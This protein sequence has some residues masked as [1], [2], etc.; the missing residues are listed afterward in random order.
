M[1]W[2]ECD[3][4]SA[5]ADPAGLNALAFKSWLKSNHLEWDSQSMQL[6]TKSLGSSPMKSGRAAALQVTTDAPVDATTQQQQQQQQQEQ[7]LASFGLNQSVTSCE[8]QD[9]RYSYRYGNQVEYMGGSHFPY[10]DPECGDER[11]IRP[12]EHSPASPQ[13]PTN[14][15]QDR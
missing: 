10:L 5:V 4:S 13:T 6:E 2:H 12:T 1:K 3:T 8:E 7:H 9:E 14:D 15:H 11:R